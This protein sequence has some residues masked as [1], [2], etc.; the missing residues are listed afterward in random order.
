MPD[1]PGPRGR[2]GYRWEWTR[3]PKCRE[4]KRSSG[5]PQLETV[6]DVETPALEGAGLCLD[7]HPT[8]GPGA[9]HPPR[10]QPDDGPHAQVAVHE[11]DVE[12]E[13]HPQAVHRAG[14]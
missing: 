1:A 5:V 2:R 4:P 11:G 9:R 3:G 10:R 7:H 14:A 6:T 12:S 13:A 8:T